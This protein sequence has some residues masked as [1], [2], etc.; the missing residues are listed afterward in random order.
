MISCFVTYD[1]RIWFKVGV[2]WIKARLYLVTKYFLVWRVYE[3]ISY[4]SD[5]A[6]I[7]TELFYK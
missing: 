5:L 4:N 7:V 6:F 1:T 3:L 2:I